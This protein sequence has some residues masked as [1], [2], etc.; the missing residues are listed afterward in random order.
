MRLC[1]MDMLDRL[2]SLAQISGSA[3]VQCLF[4][5]GWY[6]RHEVRRG[7]ALVHIVTGGTGWLKADAEAQPRRLYEGDVVFFPR[8]A[9]HVLS[10]EEGCANS[11]AA[12][13]TAEDGAFLRKKSGEG[14]ADLSLFC[15]R[16]SYDTQADLMAGLPETVVL[17]MRGTPLRHL[18]A[19][20]QTEA[21][22][23]APGARST[24]DALATVLLVQL[25]RVF[26]AEKRLSPLPEGVIRGW[27]D[28][29]LRTVIRAVLDDPAHPW[30]IE[31]M[32]ALAGVSRAQLM[33]LF[34]THTAT[35]PYA[36][37]NRIRLQ[38]AA[39][40]LKR[41]A[42]SVLAVALDVGFGS[43]THFGKAFKRMYGITPGQYRKQ[44]EAAEADFVI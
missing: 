33:R 8:G 38:Q 32:A 9:A 44:S 2:V 24:V 41:S 17:N 23:T 7:R 40:R 16:F 30:A 25:L 5:G 31:E 43:E 26:L 29:R 35:S 13:E 28:R 42:D 3:D 21:D 39:V 27:R 11:G 18:L 36:F 22:N 15:A 4:Q 12:V 1:K 14:A 34:K 6:V 19:L 37:V 20:L 10:S